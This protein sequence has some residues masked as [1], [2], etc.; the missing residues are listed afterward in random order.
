M[1]WWSNTQFWN[2]E[3][4]SLS[5]SEIILILNLCTLQSCLVNKHNRCVY[6][7][8]LTWVEFIS[9]PILCFCLQPCSY[10]PAVLLSLAFCWCIS[11]LGGRGPATLQPMQCHG[12]HA[13]VHEI[14]P[15]LW[16]YCTTANW[17][18]KSTQDMFESTT[19]AKRYSNSCCVCYEWLV[20]EAKKNSPKDFNKFNKLYYGKLL[21]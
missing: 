15:S 16:P 6:P 8:G 20:D 5:T 10:Q 14:S 11:I 4:T 1:C 9:F 2:T 19:N 7:Q 13:D 21:S 18:M 3:K 17:I 12:L